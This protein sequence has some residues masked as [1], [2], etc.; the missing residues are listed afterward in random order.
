[1]WKL[2]AKEP[3]LP[4]GESPR[5]TSIS[6][7]L[8]ARTPQSP[9]PS[10]RESHSMAFLPLHQGQ[11]PPP[12]LGQKRSLRP[13]LPLELVGITARSLL[14]GTTQQHF[15]SKCK[16]LTFQSSSQDQSFAVTV[17]TT[18]KEGQE[19]SGW[20]RNAFREAPGKEGKG[21]TWESFS[22]LSFPKDS[23][24]SQTN[25]SCPLRT[26]LPPV[27]VSWVVM[28]PSEVTAV[29]PP[30]AAYSDPKSNALFSKA[31]GSGVRAPAHNCLPFYAPSCSRETLCHLPW[32]LLQTHSCLCPLPTLS[33]LSSCGPWARLFAT[34]STLGD[35]AQFHPYANVYKMWLGQHYKNGHDSVRDYEGWGRSDSS[36]RDAYGLSSHLIHWLALTTLAKQGHNACFW[37][38]ST[39]C[40]PYPFR[41]SSGYCLVPIR[42]DRWTDRY[43]H[44]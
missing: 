24:W 5:C 23:I 32:S 10:I 12:R 22:G 18:R 21:G 42:T 6:L 4:R 17:S 11:D 34:P 2:R 41:H 35:D 43:R 9:R 19:G 26:H 8:S 25:R 38:S 1:M 30:F 29:L 15:S 37:V 14:G 7:L 44:T 13:V 3:E 16:Q 39:I 36:H 20:R 27:R 40:Y 28:T 31:Q 33:S